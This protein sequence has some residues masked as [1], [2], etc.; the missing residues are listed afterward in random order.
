VHSFDVRATDDVGNTDPTPAT[1]TWTV[2]T[3]GAAV[4]LEAPA[5]NALTNDSTPLFS[6]HASTQAGDSDTVNVEV[7]R[8]VSGDADELIQTLSV[9]RS[10]ANGSWSVAASPALADGTYLA[11]AT[12][13]DSNAETAYSAPRTFTVDATEPGVTLTTPAG[14]STTND[15]TPTVAGQA[16][17]DAGDSATVTV[18]L[19]AGSGVSGSPIQTLP[20]TRSGGSWSIEPSALADGTY[21]AEATQTDAAGNTGA[22]VPRSFTV[23]STAPDTAIDSGPSGNTTAPA[24]DF[25]FSS[26]EPGAT[27]ECKLDGGAWTACSA[28]MSYGGLAVGSHTFAVRAI[29]ALSNTDDTP[30]S[31]TWT[32]DPPAGGG[33]GGTGGGETGGGT[34]GGE[35]GGIVTPSGSLTFSLSGRKVLRVGGRRPRLTLSAS[36]SADCALKLSGKIVLSRARAAGLS[37]RAAAGK[38]LRLRA[39]TYRLTAGT[40]TRIVLA[41]PRRLAKQVL[42]G[43]KQRRKVSLRLTGAATSPNA[44]APARALRIRLKR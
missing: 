24:A 36:C 13:D 25:G 12:Q 20:A 21:T 14:G 32:I 38:R 44:S 39:K 26:P 15:T 1:R 34:G 10:A 40:K 17:T 3:T 5:D 16:G 19:Y 4:T 22:A 6:G 35:T 41:I 27:F 2:D 37:K 9:V 31:R 42:A 43:L 8:P 7:Y 11:Y 23:D 18:D 28:P 29:D 33:G 30:A